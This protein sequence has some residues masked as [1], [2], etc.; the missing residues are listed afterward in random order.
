MSIQDKIA[1]ALRITRTA[2]KDKRGMPLKF[3][4]RLKS[5]RAL[6]KAKAQERLALLEIVE[7][8]ED[9]GL[10][11]LYTPCYCNGRNCQLPCEH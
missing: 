1:R 5:Q 2:K 7:T 11:L 3:D 6:A 4:R 9:V 8:Q 10:V